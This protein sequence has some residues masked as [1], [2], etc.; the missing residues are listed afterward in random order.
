MLATKIICGVLVVA[1]IAA[2]LWALARQSSL[3]EREAELDKYSLHLDE[4]ANLL[5][6]SEQAADRMADELRAEHKRLAEADTYTSSYVVTLA[7]EMKYATDKAIKA[8][9]KN[10]LAMTI[11]HDIVRKFEPEEGQTDEGRK[12]YTYKFKI[13]I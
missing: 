3:D 1:A 12:K 2:V 9:A 5:A 13:V 8:N 10:R 4:R 7:D 6:A 11:A